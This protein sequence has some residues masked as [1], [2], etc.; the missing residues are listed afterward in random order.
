MLQYR[1]ITRKRVGYGS[2]RLVTKRIRQAEEG[3][4]RNS[5]TRLEESGLRQSPKPSGAKCGAL[6][7]ADDKLA[8]IA[9]ALP[10]LPPPAI[11]IILQTVR[12]FRG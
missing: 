7:A 9:D 11:E 10:H 2:I 5:V 12:A 6:G 8:E 4:E 1:T 3:L